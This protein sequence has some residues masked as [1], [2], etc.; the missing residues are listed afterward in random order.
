MVC[1]SM[2][3]LEFVN[4]RTEFHLVLVRVH[5]KNLYFISLR[6]NIGALFGSAGVFFRLLMILRNRAMFTKPVCTVNCDFSELFLQ[7]S[8]KFEYHKM[9]IFLP[10]S[11]FKS[12][13]EFNR[14]A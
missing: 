6:I 2:P 3:S 13:T 9:G 5:H 11:V 7:L 10:M 12:H 8:E 4:A 14:V 1:W